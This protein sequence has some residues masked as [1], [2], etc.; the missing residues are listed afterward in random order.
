VR[1]LL[2][3]IIAYLGYR[4]VKS[5]LARTLQPPGEKGMHNPKIDDV[6]IKDPVCGIYFP[7][8][9]GVELRQGGQVYLFCSAACRD[10][11]VEKQK[12]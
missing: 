11:F 8:R 7:R 2:L 1:L 3:I 4:V 5:W 6:M 9:E 12:K 10:R